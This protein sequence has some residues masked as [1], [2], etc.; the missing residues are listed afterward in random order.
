MGGIVLAELQEGLGL[1]EETLIGVAMLRIFIEEGLKFLGGEFP[2]FGV[3]M[4]RRHGK[5]IVGFVG[6]RKRRKIARTIVIMPN[7][8][9]AS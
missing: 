4:A 6:A 8:R 2:A 3:V 5:L 7:R 1:K 9:I